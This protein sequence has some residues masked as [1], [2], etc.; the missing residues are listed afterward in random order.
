MAL[1]LFIL[2]TRQKFSTYK[3]QIAEYL[4]SAQSLGIP[5]GFNLLESAQGTTQEEQRLITKMQSA[6]K[7]IDDSGKETAAA[8]FGDTTTIEALAAEIEPLQE[9]LINIQSRL[10][11]L[12]AE[13]KERIRQKK[14]E[15][16]HRNERRIVNNP[17]T[18][19]KSAYKASR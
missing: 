14:L 12:A 19:K 7:L 10:E 16:K 13:E 6:Y 9:K 15:E 18:P 8:L 4:K 3:K 11:K 5:K 2:D 1:L 17:I